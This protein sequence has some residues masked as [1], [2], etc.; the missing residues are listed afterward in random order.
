MTGWSQGLSG[1]WLLLNDHYFVRLATLHT[2]AGGVSW[3]AESLPC[4]FGRAYNGCARGGSRLRQ[5]AP[6]LS[7]VLRH[8]GDF[9]QVDEDWGNTWLCCVQAVY[10]SFASVSD[11]SLFGGSPRL[12]FRSHSITGIKPCSMQVFS[13]SPF[14]RCLPRCLSAFGNMLASLRVSRRRG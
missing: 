8:A 9:E 6:A 14:S 2:P 5:V 4:F 13:I 11:R 12:M 3:V 10:E 1:Q 7:R